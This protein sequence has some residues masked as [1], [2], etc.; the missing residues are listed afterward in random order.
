MRDGEII[1]LI[2]CKKAHCDLSQENMSQLYRYFGVTKARIA[3][4]TNGLQ[5]RFFSDLEEP[6]KMDDK[7]FLELD[8]TNLKSNALSEVRKMAKDAFDLGRMLSTASELK[9]TSEIKKVYFVSKNFP[10]FFL[11]RSKLVQNCFLCCDIFTRNV[12]IFIFSQ[13]A[14]FLSFVGRA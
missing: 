9:Y 6:N 3:I 5:L 7:P 4:L 2:E 1:I 11:M 8:L 14:L 12:Q 13:R 10:S